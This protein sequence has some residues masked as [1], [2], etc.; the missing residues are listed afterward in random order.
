MPPKLRAR[1]SPHHMAP[2]GCDA[3]Q[4]PAAPMARC[5]HLPCVVLLAVLISSRLAAWPLPAPL[6]LLSPPG[7]CH[8]AVPAAEAAGGGR[9]RAAHFDPISVAVDASSLLVADVGN[10]RVLRLSND[11]RVVSIVAGGGDG[12]DEGLASLAWLRQPTAIALDAT[13]GDVYIAE[14]RMSCVRRVSAHTGVITTMAGNHIMGFSGDGGPATS[15]KL[16]SYLSGLALNT[17]GDLF[18]ADVFN[19]R[20]RRV[21]AGTGIISTVAGNGQ[22]GFSGHGG[23]AT[24]A[25]FNQPSGVAMDGGDLLIVDTKNH[26]IWRVV[27]GTGI[28]TTVAG[29]GLAGFDGDGG[30]ATSA[31]LLFPFGVAVD[32]GG[33]MLIADFG[34]HRIRRVA[35]GTGIISTVAGNGV[36]GF[37]GDGGPSTS[38]SLNYPSEVAVDGGNLIIVDRFNHRVRRVASVTGIITTVVGLELAQA[39][40]VANDGSGSGGGGAGGGGGGGGGGGAS[41]A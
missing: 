24:S 3:A 26:V 4:L 38:A 5:A 12:G 28:I 21:A 36:A 1:R 18:I 34:N 27:A 30:P 23:P 7:A 8:A 15:A 10:H 35:A 25:R 9:P 17:E 6:D 2:L 29:N 19:H 40:G 39:S 11:M 20:L 41:S 14:N 37:R 31:R 33:N 32:A 13:T 16:G 22:R